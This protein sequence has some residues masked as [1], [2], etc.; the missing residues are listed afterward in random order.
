MNKNFLLLIGSFLILLIGGCV[1]SESDYQEVVNERDELKKEIEEAQRENEILNRSVLEAYRERDRLMVRVEDLKL[2]LE[3]PSANVKPA[4]K[5]KKN[6]NKKPEPP[7]E[8]EVR[9][10]PEQRAD[11]DSRP[12]DEEAKPEK[13][14]GVQ[15]YY[16]NPNEKMADVARR[17]GVPL[18]KLIQLNG[19]GKDAV[20]KKGQRLRVR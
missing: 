4:D 12:P 3:K 15:Y 10:V 18:D 20:L 9:V 17:T 7:A 11:V 16:A 1:V 8:P 14:T 2:D 6:R 5:E 19:L 13:T